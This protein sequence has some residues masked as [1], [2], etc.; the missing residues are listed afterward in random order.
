MKNIFYQIP[1]M[2]K[3]RENEYNLTEFQEKNCFLFTLKK[4][5]KEFLL[6]YHND[7]M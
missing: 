4:E 6:K 3:E 5:K 1:K 2:K 7:P